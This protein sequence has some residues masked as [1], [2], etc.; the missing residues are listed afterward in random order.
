M[1]PDCDVPVPVGNKPPLPLPLPLPLPSWPCFILALSLGCAASPPPVA[2]PPRPKPVTLTILSTNDLHGQLDPLVLHAPGAPP[3]KFRVGG[4]RALAATVAELEAKA[5]GPVLVLDA[6]DFGQGT[7]LS[8]HFQGLPV[9]A[10]HRLMGV[11]A[12]VI[13]NHEFDFGPAKGGDPKDLRGALKAWTGGAP[14]PVLTA[15]VTLAS[16]DRPDW[17]NVFPSVLL[18]AGGIK[19]GLIG[20]TTPTT[21]RVTMA[22]MVS[23][24]RF[25]PLHEPV[26]REAAALRKKGAHAVVVLAHGVGK[27]GGREPKSCKGEVFTDLLDKLPAGTVDALVMGHSHKCIWHRYRGALVSEACSRGIAVGRLRLVVDTAAGKV[28]P[29]A[30][31]VLP[32]YP[33]CHDVFSDTGS[34]DATR[35]SAT[36]TVQENPVLSRHGELVKKAGA[37]VDGYRAQLG[38][39]EARVVGRLEWALV[40]SLAGASGPGL[41]TARAM[42]NAVPGA[43]F[44]LLNPRAVRADLPAGEVTY[45]QLFAALPFENRLARVQVTGDEL[46]AL[47]DAGMSYRGD[48]FQVAGLRM[49][50]RCGPPPRV[51]GLQDSA[52]HPL[53]PR[54]LYTLALSDY[55]LSGGDGLAPVLDKLPANRKKVLPE[56]TVRGA[57]E[58]L[59]GAGV[60]EPLPATA[61]ILEDGPCRAG[62][63]PV[64]YLCR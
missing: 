57:V 13:G 53:Q 54:K 36:S 64:R 28:M 33:V 61:I 18:N 21:P 27:C 49:T 5:G 22:E 34:C 46:R 62:K 3:R 59:L 40:H 7:L 55:L 12:A 24:L 58:Q 29:G 6:G 47:L 15:N 32:P 10:L 25:G 45:G 48:I 38:Q 19:V 44:A 51:I 39:T 1:H 43:D 14:F 11:D 31:E 63:A 37:L 52:G 26:R 9:R 8:N 42:L 16:G 2:T 41:L 56:G 60:G 17:P 20:V 23:D 50:A 30:S 35:T 4:A